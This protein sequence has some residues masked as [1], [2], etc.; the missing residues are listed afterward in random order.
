M[1]RVGIS[2]G[3]NLGDR[4]AHLRRAIALLQPHRRS[5]HLLLSPIFETE[6]V[7][8]PPGSGAF[9]NAVIEI[10]TDLPPLELLEATQAIEAAMG[11]PARRET[12]AP[13]PIDL[14]LLYYDA[15]EFESPELIL[16]HPRLTQRAF[17]LRPLLAIRPDLV[18]DGSEAL[19]A[20]PG[21]R[22]IDALLREEA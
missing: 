18:P 12:N 4:L 21:V 10:E 19:L 6:P 13:R 5:P 14:D 3:S 15:I 17:V 9:Y 7:D 1:A 11:R 20:D 8:C 2:L 16:P 22:E